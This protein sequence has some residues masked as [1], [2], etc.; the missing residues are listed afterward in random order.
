MTMHTPD[1][2]RAVLED[3]NLSAVAAAV[4][5]HRETLYRFMRGKSLTLDSF[6]KLERYLYGQA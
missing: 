2:L 6:Q 5:L 4:G 1:Q 3:R